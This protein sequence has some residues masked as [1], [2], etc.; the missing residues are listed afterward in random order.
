[1]LIKYDLI[2]ILI[3]YPGLQYKLFQI[4]SILDKYL[5]HYGINV[6]FLTDLVIFQS[7][8]SFGIISSGLNFKAAFMFPLIFILPYC[9]MELVSFY[10]KCILLTCIKASWPLNFPDDILIKSSS[11]ITNVASTLTPS[12]L[13]SLIYPVP[14]LRSRVKMVGLSPFFSLISKAYTACILAT[15][16]APCY[17]IPA[18]ILLKISADL[19]GIFVLYVQ[20]KVN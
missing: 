19:S 2:I 12:I 3:R 14:F 5:V 20:F 11:S 6:S 1:M 18:P 13:P 9:Y 4:Y 17:P 16:A 15:T 8:A 10:I 7:L